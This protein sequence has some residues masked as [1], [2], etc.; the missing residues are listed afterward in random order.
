MVLRLAVT[1]KR[2]KETAECIQL[3]FVQGTAGWCSKCSTDCISVKVHSLICVLM[4]PLLV[5]GLDF[6]VLMLLHCLKLLN[7]G[8]LWVNMS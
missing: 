3:K 4:N 1:E 5:N 6:H 8:A 7:F 2:Q